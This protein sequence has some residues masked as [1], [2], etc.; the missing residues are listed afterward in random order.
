MGGG[1][2]GGVVEGEKLNT[3]EL[4]SSRLNQNLLMLEMAPEQIEFPGKLKTAAPDNFDVD[5]E[6]A[7]ESVRSLINQGD[8]LRRISQGVDTGFVDYYMRAKTILE[9]MVGVT[10]GEMVEDKVGFAGVV[11]GEGGGGGGGGE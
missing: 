5:V 10:F 9:H 7:V 1:G 6:R 4:R 11:N 8:T 2:G 3:Y